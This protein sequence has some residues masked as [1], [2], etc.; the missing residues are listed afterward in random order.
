MFGTR[1]SW[2]LVTNSPALIFAG[3]KKM[4]F[5]FNLDSRSPSKGR[6]I[7]SV[8][9]RASSHGLFL[10][11]FIYSS[12]TDIFRPHSVIPAPSWLDKSFGWD[13][14][15]HRRGRVF[16]S[17]SSLT[18]FRLSFRNCLSCVNDCEPGFFF[19]LLSVFLSCE[20]TGIPSSRLEKAKN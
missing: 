20:T 3:E 12:F 13:L 8:W 16:E 15:R 10:N 11:M 17:R 2:I 19:F 9:S 6:C 18:F 14:H 7:R 5:I 1:A 4:S